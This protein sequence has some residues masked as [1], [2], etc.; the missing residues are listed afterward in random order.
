MMP[1]VNRSKLSGSDRSFIISM[2]AAEKRGRFWPSV[3]QAAW[4]TRLVN[5]FRNQS[6]ET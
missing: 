1:I 5:D 4:M 3:K 2:M 6:E